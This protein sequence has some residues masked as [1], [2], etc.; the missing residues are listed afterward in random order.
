[1][2]SALSPCALAPFF[3]RLKRLLD[4]ALSRLA[5]VISTLVPYSLQAETLRSFI[6]ESAFNPHTHAELIRFKDLASVPARHT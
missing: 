6:K 4:E 5:L 3:L 1:M 2:V